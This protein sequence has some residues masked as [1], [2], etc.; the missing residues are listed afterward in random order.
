MI[1][2]RLLAAGDVV[3]VV[4]PSWGG[5]ARFPDTFAAGLQTLASLGLEVREY[6]S[7]RAMNASVKERVADLDA[8][9]ADPDI[10][11]IVASIGG[12][13]SV[14]LLPHLDP[15]R[16]RENAKIV[17]G[18]SDT[19]TL[20]SF[21]VHHGCVAFHGPSV[22]AGLAQ[23]GAF[24]AAFLDGLRTVLFDAAAPFEYPPFSRYCDGY[25][26]WSE[27]ANA[28]RPKK[29]RRDTGPRTVLGRGVARGRLWGGCLE[30]LEV[31]NQAD[32]QRRNIE[33]SL[34]M[35]PGQV[36][37]LVVTR[38]EKIDPAATRSIGSVRVLRLELVDEFQ[39]RLE[40]IMRSYWKGW[41]RGDART[42]LALRS[43]AARALPPPGWLFRAIGS[44]KDAFIT[45]DEL[46]KEWP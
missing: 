4:S 43:A 35:A 11:A 46:F 21:L 13:D 39:A 1:K 26:S 18:Y 40:T 27:P 24:P 19:T 25:E 42:R 45:I 5:P 30:T 15:E 8:A 31:L 28:A 20:L 22:M 7:T 41:V 38:V 14:R 33:A 10:E 44:A 17:L 34:K 3:A 37:S 6:P 12:D 32:G 16:I 9:F 2:P 23:A 29:L 36:A